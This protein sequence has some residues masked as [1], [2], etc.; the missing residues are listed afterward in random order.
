T[1]VVTPA[2]ASRAGAFVAPLSPHPSIPIAAGIT[3]ASNPVLLIGKLLTFPRSSPPAGRSLRHHH[4]AP[5]HRSITPPVP[6]APAARG[7]PSWYGT[8]SV[9][10]GWP[11]HATRIAGPPPPGPPEPPALPSP[12]WPPSPPGMFG[13][14]IWA[15]LPPGP[16]GW[17]G[18]PSLPSPPSPPRTV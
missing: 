11:G 10:R 13:D 7:P 15:P 5:A 14:D 16:P 1:P 18:P 2:S 8:S 4:R 17:P 6:T 12:P 9:P 3:A